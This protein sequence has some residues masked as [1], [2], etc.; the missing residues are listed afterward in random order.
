MKR[1]I[2]IPKL[3]LGAA[4]ERK[5]IIPKLNLRAAKGRKNIV[6]KLNLRA[7]KVGKRDFVYIGWTAAIFLC[8]ALSIFAFLFASCS[9]GGAAPE[10][11]PES[12]SA[13]SPALSYKIE[14]PDM[15]FSATAMP[16]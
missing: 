11:T 1:K 12:P 15:M 8:V 5:T 2:I 10:D 3:N 7:A 4:K 16:I 9:K 14:P 13:V 6:P